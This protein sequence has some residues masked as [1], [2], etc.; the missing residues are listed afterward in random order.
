[1]AN[2]AK[3][4][5]MSI[6]VVVSAVAAIVMWFAVDV[7]PRHPQRLI[8]DDLGCQAAQR[9]GLNPSVTR[10]GVCE[11]EESVSVGLVWVKIGKAR[12]DSARVIAVRDQD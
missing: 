1:M 9:L 8:L 3:Q 12:I 11:R 5:F 7:P 6:G 2:S 10:M 4:I